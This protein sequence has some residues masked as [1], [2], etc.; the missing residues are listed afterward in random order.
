MTSTGTYV[1]NEQNVCKHSQ[2][3]IF[4]QDLLKEYVCLLG[5]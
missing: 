1:W 2:D 4:S 3:D 5:I